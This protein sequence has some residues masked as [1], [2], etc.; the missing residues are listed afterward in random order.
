M[1]EYEELDKL[2]TNLLSTV[3][4]ELRTPLAIIKGYS[5]ML[6]DYDRKLSPREKSG[7][8]R[9]IDRATDRLTD[10]V[11]RLLDMSRLDAGLLKLKKAPTS[12][13]GMVKEAITEARLR[14]RKHKIVSHIMGR[15]PRIDIDARR[16]RQV[17]DNLIDNAVK[18]SGEGSSVVVEVM[19]KDGGGLQVS[20]ADQGIGIPT[21]DLE[22]VFDRMYRLEQRLSTDPGGMGLGL[23]LCKALV[24]A[25][26]GEIWAESQVEEGSTF[27]F[28]IPVET[29]REDK[30]GSDDER[31]KDSPHN[32]G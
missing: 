5:T 2:K 14:A 28:T 4:H 32:R 31:G 30:D 11:D 17:L 13:S 21:E 10:L 24:E 15:L 12:V 26:D 6:L 23:A 20:I 29:K 19:K 25:H 9:S 7:N 1:A 27:Y 22:K 16:I 8:L 18:Y 3:S